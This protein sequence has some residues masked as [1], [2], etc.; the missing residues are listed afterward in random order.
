LNPI[1]P[2]FAYLNATDYDSIEVALFPYDAAN[3][4]GTFQVNSFTICGVVKQS[5]ETP[6]VDLLDQNEDVVAGQ[7]YVAGPNSFFVAGFPSAYWGI[8]GA[9]NNITYGYFDYNDITVGDVEGNLNIVS[10]YPSATIFAV[11]DYGSCFSVGEGLL[12]FD[13]APKTT[14]TATVAGKHSSVKFYPNPAT[15]VINVTASEKVNVSIFS[16]DGKLIL[17]EKDAKSINVESLT[18]GVYFI[19]AFDDQG[20]TMKI[21]KMIKQ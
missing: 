10:C 4:G 13:C 5:C 9:A 18:S 16:V 15:N 1:V 3:T 7:T 11:A 12:N 21:E 2:S 19:K 8:I 14:G 17:D 6:T 20:H